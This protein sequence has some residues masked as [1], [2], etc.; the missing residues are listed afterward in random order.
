MDP[1]MKP[2]VSTEPRHLVSFDCAREYGPEQYF[3]HGEVQVLQT[4]LGAYREAEAKPLSRFGYRF[5]IEKLGQPH[6]VVIRYPDDK[7]R[8]MCVMD[9]T[10]YDLTTG[11]FTGGAQALSGALLELRQVFWPRWHDC[12]IVFMTWSEGEPAAVADFAVYE[13]PGLPA[14]PPLGVSAAPEPGQAT[15]APGPRREF[16][17]QYEDPCGTCASVGALNRQEWIERVVSYARHSGQDLLVY[18]LAWYHGP[19]FPSAREPAGILD[20]IAAP[21]RRLYARWTSQPVDWYAGLLERLGQEG[22]GF[23]GSLTLIRLGSLMRKMNTDLAAVQAGADTINN[24]LFNNVVRGGTGDWTWPYSAPHFT[25]AAD[26]LRPG[27]VGP[28]FQGAPG[29]ALPLTVAPESAPPGLEAGP[30]FNPLHPVVQEAILGFVT[31]AAERYGKYPAFRGLSINVYAT[32]M[33][34]FGSLRAGYDD[35]TVGLFERETGMRVPVDRSAPDRFARRFEFLTT[36]ARP[37]WVAWRC[38]KVRHLLC[39]LRDAVVRARADLRLTV[40]LWQET[41]VPCLFDRP[42]SVVQ[43]LHARSNTLR[44]F[45]EGGIDIDL[46][47]DEPGLVFDIEMGN[48]RDRGWGFEGVKAPLEQTAMFRDH[49]FLDQES[50]DALAAQVLPGVFVFNCWVEAWG[51]FVWWLC[52]PD[53]P[54]VAALQDMDGKPAERLLRMNCEYPKDGFWWEPQMRI[55]PPFQAGHFL[56]PF[57]HAV[58]ELDACR[59]T[60]GGLFLDTSHTEETRRFA[61]AYRALPRRKFETVGTRTDPVAVRSLLADGE[62]YLY[63]VNRECYPIE[64]D[65]DFSRSP[66]RLYD[67]AQGRAVAAGRQWTVTLGAYD[68]R[69]FT[70]PPGVAVRSFA[71]RLPPDRAAGLFREAEAALADLCAAR[72]AGCGVPGLDVV[73]RGLRA[74]LAVRRVAWLRRALNSYAVRKCRDLRDLQRT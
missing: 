46:F 35:Y 65:V 11:V 26:T 19:Q 17:I 22:I 67:L 74:A 24:V 66:R 48:C 42:I 4:P 27:E 61:L 63:L 2:S 10:F 30:I 15:P 23:Q 44:L 40:T 5:R 50:L 25:A 38:A 1:M 31:E 68:L 51:K 58:A 52:E 59:I 70:A 53:D 16:G 3:A 7:R 45:Q 57:A 34:W 54:N 6:E 28:A 8:F 29:A 64:V 33:L 20:C 32:T 36:Q 69:A 49:D 9:G 47:R 43:Q 21:D 60:R 62:R 37:A 55:T 13:L 41:L 18:P 14:L 12:S 72:A 39:Q 56:E 73:E 71:V